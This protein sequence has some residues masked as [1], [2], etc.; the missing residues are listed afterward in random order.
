L[1]R[2]GLLEDAKRA[3][4]AVCSDHIEEGNGCGDRDGDQAGTHSENY[5]FSF[6]IDVMSGSIKRVYNIELARAL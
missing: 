1:R 5:H 3:V 2:G 6:L 4:V